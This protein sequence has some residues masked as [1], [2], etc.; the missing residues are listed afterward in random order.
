MKNIFV[1]IL[2]FT[3]L[4]L[5]YADDQV[6]IT[7]YYP[8]PYGVYRNLQLAP[9]GQPTSG[10]TPGV[11]YYNNSQ[12]VIKFRNDTGW[13]N[14]TGQLDCTVNSQAT[15][16]GPGS[17]CT[18]TFTCPAGYKGISAGFWGG[19]GIAPSMLMP[20]GGGTGWTMR[21]SSCPGGLYVICCKND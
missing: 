2:L 7:T 16:P 19:T 3:V 9:T 6:T 18:A 5:A 1:F 8:S 17:D 10:V 14:L 15:T 20:I 11:M 21:S 4:I 12:N 13:Q